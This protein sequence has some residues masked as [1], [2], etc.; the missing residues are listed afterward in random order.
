MILNTTTMKLNKE[1]KVS[2]IS[3]Q[4]WMVEKAIAQ[5]S[6]DVTGHLPTGNELGGRFWDMVNVHYEVAKDTG[7][8]ARFDYY[9]CPFVI[10]VETSAHTTVLPTKHP[11]TSYTPPQPPHVPTPTLYTT[12]PTPPHSGAPGVP[13]RHA[14]PEPQSLL[15]ALPMFAVLFLRWM[16]S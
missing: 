4:T 13:E 1:M 15:L 2:G 11:E 9:H 3:E 10:A 16:R 12:I 8:L 6:L 7:H 5:E 14:V